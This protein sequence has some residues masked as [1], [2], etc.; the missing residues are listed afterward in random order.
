[1][2]FIMLFGVL[3]YNPW[4]V[5]GKKKKSFYIFCLT[6]RSLFSAHNP[7]PCSLS[8]QE[9]TTA[10]IGNRKQGFKVFP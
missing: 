7:I 10:V 4:D 9:A 3:Y 8:S 6:S 2:Y 5:L 1:M